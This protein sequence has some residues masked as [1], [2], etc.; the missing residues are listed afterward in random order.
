MEVQ[1]QAL[2]AVLKQIMG[3]TSPVFTLL[4]R[5]CAGN[6]PLEMLLSLKQEYQGL[7]L[8]FSTPFLTVLSLLTRSPWEK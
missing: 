4:L 2:D 3:L 1:D 8:L 6:V 7:R 5:R